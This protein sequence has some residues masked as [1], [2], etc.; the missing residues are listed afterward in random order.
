MVRPLKLMAYSL[1]K[2]TLKA[3]RLGPVML[4]FIAV[5]LASGCEQEE[6]YEAPRDASAGITMM[7]VEEL[8]PM[9]SFPTPQNGRLV[10]QSAG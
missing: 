3:L 5:V 9:P 2:M 4:T 7:T 10:T 6:L 1:V 8:P